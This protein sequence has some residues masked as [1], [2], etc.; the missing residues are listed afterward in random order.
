MVP[1]RGGHAP[2]AGARAPAASAAAHLLFLPGQWAGRSD[3]A[4][5]ISIQG[6]HGPDGPLA[7][8]IS[9]SEGRIDVESSDEQWVQLDYAVELRRRKADLERFHP[10]Y[11]DRVLFAYGPAFLIL[12]SEQISSQ[13]R[14]IPIEVRAPSSW[15]ML[16][17]WKQVQARA[18]HAVEGATVHG[19]LAAT[20]GA[21]RDAFIAAGPGL[22]LEHPATGAHASNL[23]VGFDPAV[24]VDRGRFSARIAQLLGAYRQRFGDVGP[25]SAYVRAISGGSQERRGVGRRGG[26]VVEIPADQPLDD[27]A[28]LLLAHEAFHLWNGH[29]LTP[30]PAAERQTRW[31]KEGITHYMAIKTLASLGLFSRSDVLRELSRSAS[32]YE[33]NP[34]ARG[35]R[36]TQTDRARLPYDR[37]VLLGVGLDAM[38]LRG[39]QGRIGLQDWVA[40]LLARRRRGGG[41][42]D[43]ADLRAALV[44]VSGSPSS[45]AVKLWDTY[46]AGAKTLDPSTIFD[47]AGLHWLDRGQ[48]EGSRLLPVKRANSPFHKMFPQPAPHTATNH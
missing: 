6:A 47:L 24:A 11:F 25:V 46:V 20:P 2:V 38:L 45:P 48:Q 8:T 37:G 39:S 28:L 19:Y 23:T 42:Y 16:A 43:A 9:R 41:L 40:R 1:D 3:Y 22:H 13:V 35:Q 29:F 36:S 44:E 17:T 4:Q 18:S 21:L 5:D 26:F 10:R 14:D 27:Q 34:A 31:F 7:F 12:P 33:R 32:Y 15:H 30:Q